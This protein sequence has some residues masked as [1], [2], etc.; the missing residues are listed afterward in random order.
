M[1]AALVRGSA[2]D[3][4]SEDSPPRPGT[5]RLVRAGAR[6]A[7][8]ARWRAAMLESR[9]RPGPI[10]WAAII[11]A[12]GGSTRFAGHTGP[13]GAAPLQCRTCLSTLPR[14]FLAPPPGINPL[15][16]PAHATSEL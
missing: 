9:G 4:G 14:L 12:I 16:A 2:S 3:R 10:E 6:T 15:P 7:R 11:E 5:G 1:S 13:P 8:S